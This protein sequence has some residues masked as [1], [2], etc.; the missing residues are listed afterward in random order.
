MSD[1]YH[2]PIVMSPY[3]SLVFADRSAYTCTVWISFTGDW[4]AAPSLRTGYACFQ[5]RSWR[6]FRW[7]GR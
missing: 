1:V 6:G 2:T 5:C 4:W 7:I 3:F